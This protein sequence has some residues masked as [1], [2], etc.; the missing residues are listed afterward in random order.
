MAFIEKKSPTV[1]K[2]K[3]TSKGRDLLSQGKLNFKYFEIG[4]SEIDYNFINT[5][6]TNTSD[7]IAIDNYK[8]LL[9]VPLDKNH[10][11][12]SHIY[13]GSTTGSTFVPANVNYPKQYIS[14]TSV[15]DIGFF[16]GNTILTDSNHVKQSSI[17]IDI[18][19]VNGGNSINLYKSSTYINSS[20]EPEIGDILMIKWI[21]KR[22]TNSNNNLITNNTPIPYIFYKITGITS[23]TL[24]ANN[25]IIK[26]DRELPN[27]SLVSGSA[28]KIAGAILFYNKERYENDPLSPVDYVSTNV[29]NFTDNFQCD[30]VK[31]PL[32]NLNIIY[33]EEIAGVSSTN[34]K[35]NSLN[36]AGLTGF[37]SYIQ[38][39]SPINKKL[40]VIHYTNSSPNNTY[41]EGFYHNT[42]ILNI[43]TVMWYRSATPTMGLTL[44][45]DSFQ[46]TLS[47]LNITYYNLVDNTGYVVGKIFDGLKIFV[48]EDQ[49]L[50][51]AMSFKSNRNWTL[52]QFSISVGANSFCMTTVYVPTTTVYVPTTTAYIAPSVVSFDG[53]SG[54]LTATNSGGKTYS[55][56]ISY[57]I[58]ADC[59]NIGNDGTDSNTATTTFE[60]SGAVIDS[61]TATVSGGNYPNA[62][63]DTQTINGS[64]TI[65]GV[66]NIS[67]IYVSGGFY[68]NFSGNGQNGQVTATISSVN[69]NIGSANIGCD[70]TWFSN[71]SGTFTQC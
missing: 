31:Y 20:P 5:G 35:Y 40:G 67:S 14:T 15:T 2:V 25:L 58:T 32:W 21:N 18:D 42:P 63:N 50:L 39:Q 57:T 43:P 17:Q 19:S 37:I 53:T 38:N 51:F 1:L 41:G 22:G 6:N 13:S 52:P 54:A 45:G 16:S 64:H 55:I 27:Y 69:V 46:K 68:C 65:N 23:G 30:I 62:Q 10:N 12:L 4:D 60:V 8:P 49:D 9:L 29:L 59:D 28:G 26:V 24:A 44:S 7:T 33:T 34:L 70:S 11:I 71:C 61:V 3:I 36:S 56:T 66:T 47:G 48:I